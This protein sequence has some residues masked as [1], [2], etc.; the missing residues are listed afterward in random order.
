[1]LPSHAI[2][3]Q[4]P[5]PEVKKTNKPKFASKPFFI[6]FTSCLNFPSHHDYIFYAS[7]SKDIIACIASA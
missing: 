3:L 7:A 5:D 4:A 2:H 6:L 1:M